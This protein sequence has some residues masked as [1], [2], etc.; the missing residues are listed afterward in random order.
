ME[1]HVMHLSNDA[2]LPTRSLETT[3]GLSGLLTSIM[4]AFCALHRISWSAPWTEQGQ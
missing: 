3:S 4:Q 2:R 1:R